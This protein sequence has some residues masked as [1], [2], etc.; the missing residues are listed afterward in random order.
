MASAS[1]TSPAFTAL[2]SAK[3][4]SSWTCVTR[5]S[6]KKYREKAVAW[7]ATSTNP[8]QYRVRV[9]LEHP[10]DRA[11]AQ[12]LR[13]R[14]HRPHQLLGR[15]ALAMQGRAMVLLEVA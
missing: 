8:L 13:Q 6:C 2:S 10:G 7:S 3:S 1:L 9:H 11:D 12:A 4:S 15:H 14:A 5:T